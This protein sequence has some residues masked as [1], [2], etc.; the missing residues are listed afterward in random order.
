MIFLLIS[1]EEADGKVKRIIQMDELSSTVS[2]VNPGNP[3]DIH[4]FTFDSILWSFDGYTEQADGYLSPDNKM[5][6]E[7]MYCDQVWLY[8]NQDFKL[9]LVR[10]NF[11]KVLR[12]NGKS[13]ITLIAIC[14]TGAMW[15][16]AW[17]TWDSC[18]T[19]F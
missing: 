4:K 7:E 16:S 17:S 9:V 10:S 15:D 2:L 11:I 5:A 12:S 6:S 13:I 3:A 8:S 19:L 14:N 1:K 18:K